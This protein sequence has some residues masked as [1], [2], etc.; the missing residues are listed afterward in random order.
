MSGQSG[1]RQ[2]LRHRQIEI[3][4]LSIHAVEGGGS[5]RPAVLFL[6]GW[7]ESWA[8]FEQILLGLAPDR[9]VV[10]V[11]LPGIGDSR[12]PPPSGDKR[13][14][15]KAVRGVIEAL[16]LHDVTLVGH[17]V[18]GMIAYA[19]LRICP[20]ALRR[21]VIMNVAIPA[22]APW[23][24][25]KGNPHIWHFAFHAIPGLPEKLVAGRQAPYF[26]YFFETIAARPDA[27]SPNARKTYAEAYSRPE[28]LRC[29]F[30]WYRAFAQDEKDNQR[31]HGRP[32]ELPVLYLRGEKDPGLEL[33]RYADGL[34]QA[35][36][37]D[38]TGRIIAGSGHFAPDEQPEAVVAALRDFICAG[39]DEF[40][41]T[42]RKYLP[43]NLQA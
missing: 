12:N 40:G 37:R 5:G 6:H 23:S 43:A 9:H 16:G 36:L 21:A 34:R 42:S 2:T 24:E 27:V 15:A 4:G 31:D 26:D 8:A 13:T 1:K 25:V 11:D 22:V 32:V 14:L 38:V 7:P 29:G 41:G 39:R 33:D 28:A 35:G 19:C 30:E 3:E 10:A 18:G 20:D 17:D